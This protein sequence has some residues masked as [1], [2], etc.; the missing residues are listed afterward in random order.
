MDKWKNEYKTLKTTSDITI[1]K[2]TLIEMALGTA[3][4]KKEPR[5]KLP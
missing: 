1:R 2:Y 5:K 3:L 4:L